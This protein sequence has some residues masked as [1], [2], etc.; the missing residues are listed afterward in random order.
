MTDKKWIL[1]MAIWFIVLI[2][3]SIIMKSLLM[4][5]VLICIVEIILGIVGLIIYFLVGVYLGKKG[6]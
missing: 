1:V 4:P 3:S 5:G 2:V 6:K